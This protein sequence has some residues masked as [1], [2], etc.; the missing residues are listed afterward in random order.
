MAARWDHI[1][2][3]IYPERSAFLDLPQIA[4]DLA[5]KPSTTIMTL[6]DGKSSEKATRVSAQATVASIVDHKAE[7]RD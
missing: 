3:D 2:P 4:C 5:G 1:Y 7:T 6:V